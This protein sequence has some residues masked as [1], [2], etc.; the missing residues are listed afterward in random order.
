MKLFYLTIYLF[1]LSITVS[2]QIPE[3]ELNA[4][5][6][7]YTATQ[8]KHW[9][10]SWPMDKAVTEWEG[11]TIENNH[12]TEIKML[13]NNLE[14]VLP[15]TISKLT[16]LR[17]LELSFNKITGTLPTT[18]GDLNY[19]EV[20]ALNGNFIE[21]SIPSSFG[22][23]THLK[24][25][26]LSS[27]RLSGEIPNTINSLENLEVFNV[28][29][30]QLTGNLPVVLSRS[31]NLKEFIIAKNKFNNSPE[32]STILLSNSAMVDLEEN[33]VYSSGKSIIAIETSDDDH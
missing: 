19:L 12:V 30:N 5:K 24:Q 33:R 16:K 14:G 23:L 26:H 25:L 11:I 31:R 1:L 2:A 22:N 29:E 18:I 13:F 32:I 10:L 3:S 7:L 4:L 9:K 6:D 8:G 27:N 28:F 15:N 17:V 21:G 20:L